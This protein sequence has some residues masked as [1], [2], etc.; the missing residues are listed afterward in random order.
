MSGKSAILTLK[1]LT[2]ASDDLEKADL[3]VNHIKLILKDGSVV[4]AGVKM[5]GDMNADGSF[6]F[7]GGLQSFVNSDSVTAV[8]IFGARIPLINKK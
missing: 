3:S 4:D 5:G 1:D 6:H 8:E 7:N 2:Y